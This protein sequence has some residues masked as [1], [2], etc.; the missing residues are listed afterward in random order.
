MRIGSKVYFIPLGGLGVPM[1][2][3]F[4]FFD[5]NSFLILFRFGVEKYI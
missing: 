1:Q 2:K 3:F 4:L 5:E